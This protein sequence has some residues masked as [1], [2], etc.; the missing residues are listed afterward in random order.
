ML[1]INLP[2]DRSPV[3]TETLVRSKAHKLLLAYV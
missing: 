1:A 2:A 3:K